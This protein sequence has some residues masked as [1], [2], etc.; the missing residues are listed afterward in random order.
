[1]SRDNEH[2]IEP[3]TRLIYALRDKVGWER[4][5]EQFRVFEWIMFLRVRHTIT[6]M[7]DRHSHIITRA[8]GLTFQIQTNNQ[9]LR[10]SSVIDLY[11]VE[12]EW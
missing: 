2:G 11:P 6:E 4:V 3:S 8:D 9:K 1:M 5:F 10:L 7:S 12:K